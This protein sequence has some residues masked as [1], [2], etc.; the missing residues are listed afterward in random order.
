MPLYVLKVDFDIKLYLKCLNLVC[1][2][3]VVVLLSSTF[4]D[5]QAIIPSAHNPLSFVWASSIP[6]SHQLNILQKATTCCEFRRPKVLKKTNK[7]HLNQ[8]EF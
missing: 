1:L 2:F 4:I 7:T 3:F 6:L 8:V 5:E